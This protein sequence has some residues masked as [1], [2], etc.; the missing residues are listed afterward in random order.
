[1]NLKSDSHYRQLLEERENLRAKLNAGED[2][3][4]LRKDLE[5]AEQA[6]KEYSTVAAERHQN[7]V[8]TVRGVLEQH[9]NSHREAVAQIYLGGVP[10]IAS[11]MIEYVKS[12]LVVFGSGV[13][14]FMVV[15][16]SL[17]FRAPKWVVLLSLIHI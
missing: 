7:L 12:D 6:F 17:I 9:R 5:L 3:P 16:L 1:M 8:A 14:L 11:D 15:L 2:N 4:A 10:M 13:L